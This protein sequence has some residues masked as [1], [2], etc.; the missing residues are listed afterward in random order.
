MKTIKI[1]NRNYIL[2]IRLRTDGTVSFAISA[3]DKMLIRDEAVVYLPEGV[4]PEDWLLKL[5]N[6]LLPKDRDGWCVGFDDHSIVLDW[7]RVNNHRL[8]FGYLGF[9]RDQIVEAIKKELK[10][11]EEPLQEFTVNGVTFREVRDENN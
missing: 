10:P 7:N 6:D 4:V 11:E 1:E 8:I 3:K 2:E 5:A 9:T